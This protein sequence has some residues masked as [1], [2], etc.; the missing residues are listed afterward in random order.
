MKNK[1]I[2][3]VYTVLFFIEQLIMPKLWSVYLEWI[4]YDVSKGVGPMGLILS[5]VFLWLGQI[6]LAFYLWYLVFNPKT[7]E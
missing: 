2:A 7:K 6:F 4:E 5:C 3:F 1:I